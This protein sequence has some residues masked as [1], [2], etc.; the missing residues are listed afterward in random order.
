VD[1][2]DSPRPSSILNKTITDDRNFYHSDVNWLVG[3]EWKIVS[4][5][6]Y[7]K[8]EVAL[9]LLLTDDM[10]RRCLCG[11][12]TYEEIA[13]CKDGSKIVARDEANLNYRK[14]AL[15]AGLALILAKELNCCSMPTQS[16]L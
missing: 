6:I 14:L 1:L 3:Y 13:L 10:L 9:L 2:C 8:Q 12:A 16:S 5:S 11:E 7:P 4:K 15:P